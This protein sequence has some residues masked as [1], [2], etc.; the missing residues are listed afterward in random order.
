MA[1]SASAKKIVLADISSV[2]V[3][4]R[5]FTLQLII[6]QTGVTQS[7]GSCA[8]IPSLPRRRS[9]AVPQGIDHVRSLGFLPFGARGSPRG[10]NRRGVF[11]K[12]AS[13][14]P[15]LSSLAPSSANTSIEGP[16]CPQQ[17]TANRPL[18]PSAAHSRWQTGGSQR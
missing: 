10:A 7:Y 16:C 1:C 11:A 9:T 3:S 14:A 5:R 17:P 4:G 8:A 13:T 6:Q 2:Y 12:A 18:A 15:L